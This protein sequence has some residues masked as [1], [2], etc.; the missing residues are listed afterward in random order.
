EPIT[1]FGD[2]QM[3]IPPRASNPAIEELVSRPYDG[4]AGL[5]TLDRS[6][7]ARQRV[8]ERQRSTDTA[9]SREASHSDGDLGAL[10]WRNP[11]HVFS[12]VRAQQ[13]GSRIEEE[14]GRADNVVEAAIGQVYLGSI[15]L[16]RQSGPPMLANHTTDLEHV[17]E[18]GRKT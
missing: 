8:A 14:R 16:R 4:R 1:G 18:V 17:G 15:D 7:T 11:E 3:Q 13:R 6:P 5:Q 10:P 2:Q 9:G 12:S